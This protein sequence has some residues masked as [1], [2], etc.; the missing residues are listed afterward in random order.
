[1]ILLNITLLADSDIHEALKSWIL[2][3]FIPSTRKEGLFESLS[4]LKV[5]NSPNEGVTYALQ[6]KAIDENVIDQ[7]RESQ[8]ISFQNKL[9]VDYPNKVY[10]FE[11]L[12]EFLTE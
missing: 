3:D 9:Q 10:F 6:F 5:L 7:F 2:N 11:S 4:L 8:L 1:M 12:M